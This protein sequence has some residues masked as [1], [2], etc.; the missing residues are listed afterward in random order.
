MRT[1]L[2]SL[3]LVV[4]LAVHG[5]RREVHI[6]SVNDMHAAIEKMPALTAII[7]S[8]RTLYP[9]LLV[10]SAGDNRTG[11]P[12]SDMY[13]I[14]GY[15]MV[16]LMN[17]AGF[18]GSALGNHEFDVH[19]L[20]TLIGYSN[21][22][23]ICANI[24]ADDTTGV[25]TVPYQLFDVEGM[26]VGVVGAVQIN[27]QGR[28]DAH[29][30]NLLGI[31]FEEPAKAVARYEWLSR[32]CD[33]TILLSHVGY[34]GEVQMAEA[35]PW[36]DLIIGGHTHTQLTADEPLHNGV[37][38]TQNR[39][40]LRKAT[41]I[42]LT[43]EGRRVIDKKAEY[44]SVEDCASQNKVAAEMVRYF[45]NNPAFRRVLTQCDTPFGSRR[46]VGC[47]ACDAL[48]AEGQADVALFNYRGI[49]IRH[50]DV[51]DFTVGDVLAMDPFGNEAV[52]LT[53]TGDELFQVI[54][55][56]SRGDMQHFPHIGGL[57][58][59][60]T[61]DKKDPSK[62]KKIKLLAA[63]G[64]IFDTKK[65][66]RIITNSYVAAFFRETLDKED[67]HTKNMQTS[68]MI[69]RYLDKQPSIS[70]H[71]VSRINIIKQ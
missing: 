60:L 30:D 33:A 52:E 2:L 63:D 24:Q 15:P 67:I 47:M 54:E 6:V 70:Y 19:S 64:G 36:L 21:F 13:E 31:R 39:H 14:P 53:L 55:Q 57:R 25:R 3:L 35:F 68:D 17:L 69:M 59:E 48:I 37:L 61:V 9:S 44:I 4:S 66:Y 46:E 43:V 40:N 65:T 32:Q 5:Q 23:Y 58:A 29:P 56:Y 49:R 45:T 38:I 27:Y 50:H 71:N 34:K 18:N 28:P 10:F 16:S 20:P 1:F 42:T 11:N 8:L 51:G 12:L 26:T 22:R 62:I 7:D 41:H